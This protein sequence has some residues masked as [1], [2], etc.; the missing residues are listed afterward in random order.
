MRKTRKRS[1]KKW[2]KKRIKTVRGGAKPNLSVSEQINNAT[3][4]S[5]KTPNNSNIPRLGETTNNLNVSQSGETTNNLNVSQSGKTTNNLNVSQSGETT[6]LKNLT[7]NEQ[8]ELEKDRVK[9]NYLEKQRIKEE[10]EKQRIKE[11]EKQR[12]KE[13]KNRQ[14]KQREKNKAE[15]NKHPIDKKEDRSSKINN[16]VRIWLSLEDYLN[17]ICQ[18]YNHRIKQTNMI[19]QDINTNKKEI[20]TLQSNIKNISNNIT[21]WYSSVNISKFKIDLKFDAILTVIDKLYDKL[22][23]AGKIFNDNKTSLV[24]VYSNLLYTGKIR[25]RLEPNSDQPSPTLEECQREAS[26]II[27]T[28]IKKV[29]EIQN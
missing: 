14:A 22:K 24:A 13:L 19:C 18:A 6:I 28:F 4:S 26:E 11:L 5:F 16:F 3:N 1:Y 20:D 2:I 7:Q 27:D 29:N 21:A 9:Q 10:L 17:K 23:L 25:H 15:R 12:I 8:N